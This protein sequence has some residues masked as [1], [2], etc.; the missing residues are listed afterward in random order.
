MELVQL[1]TLHIYVKGDT[2]EVG[3]VLGLLSKKIDTRTNFDKF[4]DKLKG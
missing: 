2:P 3:D 4:R 1:H